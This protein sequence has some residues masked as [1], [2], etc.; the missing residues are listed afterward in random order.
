MS[1]S[2]PTEVG[3][4]F[5][6]NYPPFSAWCADELAAA[7]AALHAAPEAVPLG[8]YLHI[9]FCRKRCKFCY[10]R[11]YTDKRADEI[12]T[13]L[14]ALSREI[15]LV[16]QLPCLGDRPFRFVYFGGG[17]P[18]FLSVR[19]LDS[20]VARLRANIN[21][22]RAEEVTFEC[23]PGTLSQPKLEKLR[24]LGITR[25]SLGVEN[26][27][28]AVLSENGRAHQSPE[29]FRAW[30]WISEIGFPSVNIDLIAGMV[31]ESTENWRDCVQRTIEM[32][33]ESVTIYQM[34]LPYNT[35]YSQDLLNDHGQVAVADWST[36]RDW[37][38]YAF[39]E[40]GRAGYY[41]SSA[42]TMVKDPLV[43]F[44]YRDNLWQGSDML[45]TGVASFGHI[46][47]VHY[48]N[49]ADWQGYVGALD[50]SRLPL[51]RALRLTE[52]QR[53]DPGNDSPDQTGLFGY[54]LLSP[55]VS[56]GHHGGMG[57]R[58]ARPRSSRTGGTIGSASRV[59]AAGPA[60]GRPVAASV[61]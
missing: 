47:G 34:E 46:S 25:L 18:S 51:T 19:Q 59:D 21:W 40:L 17:T 2:T 14:A 22:D 3:S 54:L 56:G 44:S 16:S 24:E 32:A 36:K 42:Y 48:Q 12:E 13:Y 4:Y 45:A 9:P 8:L 53:L 39:D 23:E 30:D 61:L 20:L 58:L 50:E 60:D 15:E 31:G 43:K 57:R 29:I 37:V 33:P 5:I 1:E 38:S 41:L 7:E 27:N 52:R 6:S 10:F 28:D 11:V 26:F 35:V 55:Q 49:A